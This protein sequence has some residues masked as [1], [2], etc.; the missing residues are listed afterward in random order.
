LIGQRFD[1][2]SEALHERCVELALQRADGDELPIARA[3]GRVPRRRSVEQIVEA[4]LAPATAR[5]EPVKHRR[6]QRSAV[7]HRRIDDLAAS[8]L[9]RLEQCA[10]HAEGEQHSTSAEVANDVQRRQGLLPGSDRVQYAG[11]CDVVDIVTRLPRNR[12]VLAP[13]RHASHDDPWIARKQDLGADAET[14]DDARPKPLDEDVRA[15]RE[16]QQRLRALRS[17]EVE[18]KRAPSATHQ[19]APALAVYTQSG[20]GHAVDEQH[21]GPHVREHHAAERR[22]PDRLELDDAHAGQRSHGAMLTSFAQRRQLR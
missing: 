20:I 16:H 19:I 15:L 9:A 12:T 1:R 2:Q 8:R 5:G 10:S 4:L 21:V 13:A 7:D 17:L 22:R 14:L 11:T 3:V 6:E 18:R